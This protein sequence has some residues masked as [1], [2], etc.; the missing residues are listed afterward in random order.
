MQLRGEMGIDLLS[1]SVPAAEWLSLEVFITVKTHKELMPLR[2]IVT[3]KGFWQVNASCF[4]QRHLSSLTL[5]D[6][7]LGRRA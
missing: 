5:D 3:Q 7:F 6:P 2:A 1:K 4:L